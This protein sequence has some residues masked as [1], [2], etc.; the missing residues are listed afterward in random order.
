MIQEGRRW[1]KSPINSPEDIVESD[2]DK[3]LEAPPIQKPYPKDAALIDLVAPEAFS[4]GEMA[5]IAVLKE[6]MSRR[7]YTDEALTL[8][9]VSF[10]V[11]AVQ[12]VRRV[13]GKP[14]VTL[15]T[16]PAGGGIHPFE[17]YLVVNRVEN[18]DP[19][20]YR[21]LPM[22]HKLLRVDPVGSEWLERLV[23]ACRGQSF[24]RKGAVVFIWTAVPYRAEWRYANEAHKDIAQESGHVCQNLYLACEAIGAGTC[25][26]SGYAQDAMDSLLGVDGRDEFA[27]YVAPVGKVAE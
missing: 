27:V 24:V 2:Q 26:I 9:E 8:E 3:G 5:L 22:E 4:L 19:G 16:V 11:W 21:Y 6:R 20:L 13:G 17:T 14:P 12:G 15:R 23:F 10:L 18:L 1:L 7:K 25:A